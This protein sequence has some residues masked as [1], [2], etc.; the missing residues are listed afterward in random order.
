MASDNDES[1]WTSAYSR[2]DGELPLE[3]LPTVK[4]STTLLRAQFEVSTPGKVA[5]SVDDMTGV[6]ISVDGKPQAAAEG[7]FSLELKTG[8]HNVTLAI[9]RNARKSPVKSSSPEG[10]TTTAKVQ[11]VGGK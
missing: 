7:K 4:A 6:Q 5:F 8:L 9:D 11:L 2:V 3:G 1:S 10:A